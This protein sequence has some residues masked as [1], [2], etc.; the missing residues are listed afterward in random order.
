MI[1]SYHFLIEKNCMY[2]ALCIRPETQVSKQCCGYVTG[3]W[4]TH[5]RGIEEASKHFVTSQ[6]VEFSYK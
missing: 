5:L 2:I 3:Q 6:C 1:F 4:N